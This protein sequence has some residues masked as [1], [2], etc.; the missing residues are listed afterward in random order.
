VSMVDSPRVPE[1]SE[2]TSRLGKTALQLLTIEETREILRVSR[3]QVYQLIN[4]RQLRS[5]KIARRRLIA[6]EDLLAYIRELRA[7]A[8]IA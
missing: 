1:P 7:R 4:T 6:Q 5:V 2:I 8:E 3:W